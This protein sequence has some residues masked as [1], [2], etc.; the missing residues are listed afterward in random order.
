MTLAQRL[1]QAAA[2]ELAE[3]VRERIAELDAGAA[4][5][6][7]RN[8]FVGREVVELVLGRR[9]LLTSRELRRDLAA[10]RATPQAEALRL[11]P[12]LFWRD[13]M[14]IGLD[15]R[16]A[17]PVRRAAH[18]Q[19][20]GRLPGLSLGEKIALA[21]RADGEVL[22]ALRFDPSPRVIGALLDNPRTTEGLLAPLVH[23]ERASPA[24]LETVAANSRWGVRYPLRVGLSRNPRTPVRTVLGLLTHLKKPDLAA[25]ASH[26]RLAPAVKQRAR[27][28]LGER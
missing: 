10:C 2:E 5:Q 23:S 26:P 6:A 7:L 1:R 19:L 3:L 18:R 12:G 28:L 11:V 27:L 22:A 4:R 15:A 21:R 25:V 14:L 24:V 17:P 9:A 16:V 8:P 20:T 13:L